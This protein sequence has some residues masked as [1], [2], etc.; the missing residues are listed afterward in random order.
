MADSL[1]S[2][3]LT[4]GRCPYYLKKKKKN[5]FLVADTLMALIGPIANLFMPRQKL[6][7]NL[8]GRKVR[9]EHIDQMKLERDNTTE[10]HE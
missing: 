4:F 8:T 9:S 6:S 1:M 7:E 3:C 10:T 2:K 5:R